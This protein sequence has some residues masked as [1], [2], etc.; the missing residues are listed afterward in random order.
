MLDSDR[1]RSLIFPL[2]VLAVHVGIIASGDEQH[3][4]QKCSGWWS[5]QRGVLI[6][7]RT[8]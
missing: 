4:Q 7:D 2:L 3:M 5:N 8:E 1:Q 6:F